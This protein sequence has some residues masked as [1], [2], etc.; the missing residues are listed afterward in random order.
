M[1]ELWYGAVLFPSTVSVSLS[2][3]ERTVT[4]LS[5]GRILELGHVTFSNSYQNRPVCGCRH[6]VMNTVFLDSCDSNALHYYKTWVTCDDVCRASEHKRTSPKYIP[7]TVSKLESMSLPASFVSLLKCKS[8]KSS[9]PLWNAAPSTHSQPV[10]IKT[11][12]FQI[13]NPKHAAFDLVCDWKLSLYKMDYKESQF[14]SPC[15]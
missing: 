9:P 13:S 7:L 11:V 15:K 4:S 2:V 3:S 8:H 12:Q 1:H 10:C 6:S 5:V 14:P